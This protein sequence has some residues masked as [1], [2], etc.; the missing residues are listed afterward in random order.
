MWKMAGVGDLNAAD[1]VRERALWWPRLPRRTVRLRLTLLY[2][3]LFLVSGVGLLAITLALELATSFGGACSPTPQGTWCG[4]FPDFT[5]QVHRAE[6]VQIPAIA[7]I[8]LPAMTVISAGLGWVMAGRALR[9]LRGITATTRR[10]SADNLHERL[11]MTGPDDELKELGDTIDGLLAR[12]EGA[13]DAERRF[14]ANA[15]HELRTPLAMMRTSLDVAMAKPGPISPQL[16]VL[17]RKLGDGLDR[18]EALIEDLLVLAQ[19]Q[20]GVPPHPSTV[21]LAELARAALAGQADAAARMRL[22]VTDDLGNVRVNGSEPLLT[23]LVENLIEN[24]IRHNWAGGWLWVRTERMEQVAR[25]LVE[26]GGP[27]LD[28]EQVQE[29]TQPFRRLHGERIGQGGF[30]LGLSIVQAIVSAHGGSLEF[31]AR[32]G[33]GLQVVV[34]LALAEVG[35]G[36]YRS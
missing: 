11:D 29:L 25:L 14:V 24:A 20:H 10:I 28:P 15:S 5:A 31:R 27:A 13:F 26:N 1:G 32:P 22:R 34:Q 18:S 3:T 19:A 8:V 16:Q 33:G 2:A 12:L 36:R 30:G 4:G 6:L 9:P 35:S 23:R 17:G 21:S 7:A